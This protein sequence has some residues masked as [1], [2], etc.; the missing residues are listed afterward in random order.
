MDPAP[1]G[2]GAASGLPG[3]APAARSA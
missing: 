2:A 3:P 1:T